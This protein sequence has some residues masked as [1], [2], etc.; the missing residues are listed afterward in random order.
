MGFWHADEAAVVPD[1]PLPPA[2][3]DGVED[4]D[5][6]E[7]EDED[8]IEGGD[9]MMKDWMVKDWRMKTKS[10]DGDWVDEEIEDDDDDEDGGDDRACDQHGYTIDSLVGKGKSGS[11]FLATPPTEVGMAPSRYI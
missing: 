9:W 5:E 10:D 3:G 6:D 1:P 4:D 8:E 7:D 2:D 11:V